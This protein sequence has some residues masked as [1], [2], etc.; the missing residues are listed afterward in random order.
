M[1][2]R[3][4]REAR[5]LTYTAEE[6]SFIRNMRE[7]MKSGANTQRQKRAHAN[8]DDPVIEPLGDDGRPVATGHDESDSDDDIK[9][10]QVVVLNEDKHLTREE[11][12]D[13]K[14]EVPEPTESRAIPAPGTLPKRARRTGLDASPMAAAKETIIASKKGPASTP[15]AKRP[16]KGIPTKLSFDP[17]A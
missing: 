16:R 10:A 7:R 17:D 5:N 2:T 1:S 13:Q 12:L 6:P 4:D 9:D 14:K 11:Y 15:N 8:E 3:G